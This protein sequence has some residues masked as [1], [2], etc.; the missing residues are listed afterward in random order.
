MKILLTFFVLFFSLPVFAKEEILYCS[1]IQKIGLEG[2]SNYSESKNYNLKRHTLKIDF[3]KKSLNLYDLDIWNCNIDIPDEKKMQCSLGG[4]SFYINFDTY[5]FT[6]AKG[7]G[8][9]ASDDNVY[10]ENK[11]KLE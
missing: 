11:A 6:F 10:A 8:Y 4:W 5:K 1:E 2:E 3:Q 7:F 9:V